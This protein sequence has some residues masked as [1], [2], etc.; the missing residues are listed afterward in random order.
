MYCQFCGREIADGSEACIYC[1]KGLEATTVPG[2][3]YR[4]E[5]TKLRPITAALLGFLLGWIFLGPV[6]YIYLGQWNW[7]WITF[8]IQ[9]FAYPLTLFIAYPLLPVVFAIHQYQM[10]SE[11]NISAGFPEKPDQEAETTVAGGTG[12]GVD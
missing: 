6:G 5:F 3:M 7:F 12:T 4:H 10:A 1:G 8:L 11:L 2:K 9:I